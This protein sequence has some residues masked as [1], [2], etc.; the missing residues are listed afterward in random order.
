MV[1][2]DKMFMKKV[3]ELVLAKAVDVDKSRDSIRE[4]DRMTLKKINY[5]SSKERCL[6]LSHQQ[7]E[8][9]LNYLVRNPFD[10]KMLQTMNFPEQD[11]RNQL[12]LSVLYDYVDNKLKQDE[13]KNQIKRLQRDSKEKAR[14]EKLEKKTRKNRYYSKEEGN[15]SHL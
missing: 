6:E 5:F 9:T 2:L 7:G 4:I 10:Y 15:S 12:L 14:E 8:Y 3:N 13:L 11:L 1:S